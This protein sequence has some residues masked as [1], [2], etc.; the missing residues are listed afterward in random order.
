M[1]VKS[2]TYSKTTR[3]NYNSKGK[4]TSITIGK[5]G[6]SKRKVTFKNGHATIRV[7]SPKK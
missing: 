3:R 4:L 6:Q 1:A 5:R 7:V 2:K